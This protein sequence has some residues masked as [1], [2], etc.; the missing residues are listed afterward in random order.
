VNIGSQAIKKETYDAVIA[1][2]LKQNPPATPSLDTA[3][4]YLINKVVDSKLAAQKAELVAWVTEILNAGNTNIQEMFTK[5]QN[6]MHTV[7]R[8]SHLAI[9]RALDPAFTLPGDVP[10]EHVPESTPVHTNGNGNGHE[11]RKPKILIAG[12]EPRLGQSIKERF[13]QLDVVQYDQKGLDNRDLSGSFDLVI[14]SRWAGHSMHERLQNTYGDKYVFVDGAISKISDTI[15]NR[16]V[17]F[18]H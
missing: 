7:I 2:H 4:E 17:Q 15:N 3:F 9:M 6:S 18:I 13:P 11:K 16:V 14:G 1:Y 8:D 10:L 12:G 5:Q